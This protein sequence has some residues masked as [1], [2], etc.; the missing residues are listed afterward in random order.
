MK[1]VSFIITIA[2]MALLCLTVCSCGSGKTA[3]DPRL[4][5]EDDGR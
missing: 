1:K 5:Q 2:F 3:G 4:P